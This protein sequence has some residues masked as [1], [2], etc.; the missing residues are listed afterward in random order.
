MAK[1]LVVNDSAFSRSRVA[2][3]LQAAGYQVVEAADGVQAV[4]KY[5]DERPDAVLMDITMP[6][7]DGLNALV[8][9]RRYDPKARVMMLTAATQK[10]TAL[11]AIKMGA[12][13][14]VIKPFS[15]DRVLA[16]IRRMLGL[17]HPAE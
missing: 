14:F 2:S 3:L 4:D 11:T 16:A 7:M 1:A 5:Q 15:E 8:A 6:R 9:I 13:D 12:R 17:E 10:Q